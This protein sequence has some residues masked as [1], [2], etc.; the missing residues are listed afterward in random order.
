MKNERLPSAFIACSL[1]E[2]KKLD[3]AKS[4]NTYKLQTQTNC[5]RSLFVKTLQK[6]QLRD[7]LSFLIN[8][9]QIK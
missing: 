4:L 3:K 9:N 2:N 5:R 8:Q 1:T 7:F 6:S